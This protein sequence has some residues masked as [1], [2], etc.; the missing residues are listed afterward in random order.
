M[1]AAVPVPRRS[2]WIAEKTVTATFKAAT[3]YTLTTSVD[4]ELG[5][6][7]IPS[8]AP[9][10]GGGKYA[11]G[12][13]VQLTA[14]PAASYAFAN[15]TGSATR[16]ANPTPVTMDGD[17]MVTAHFDQPTCY[18]LVTAA[19][20]GGSAMVSANPA[21]NC[22]P[23]KYVENTEVTLTAT[24]ATDHVFAN[25]SG[26]ATGTENPVQVTMDAAKSVT[27]NFQRETCY[28]LT[29]AAS[30]PGGGSVSAL[31]APTCGG[32]DY[33]SGTV[34]QVTANPAQD[35]VFTSWA[36]DVTGPA[37]PAS[38]TLDGDKSVTAQ[39]EGATCHSLVVDVSPAG[40]GQVLLAPPANCGGGEYA[41]GTTVTLTASP[42][43]G[44]TFDHWSGDVTGT[45]NPET[46]LV[47][48][49]KLLTAHFIFPNE[50]YLPLA[51]RNSP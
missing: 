35:H 45:T 21:P 19:A 24:S 5:G 28:S 51:F 15:W 29:T 1:P 32:G 18:G 36:G 50:I 26:G 9:N 14:S 4:P 48:G 27:A 12:T 43:T 37:N 41:A 31:P 17:K 40:A 44:F 34:V 13:Q 39:F 38:I 33:V 23:D 20:P 30:P 25:W 11:A 46:L 3:C 49:D 10:C 8:P 6:T 47:D 16:T 22:G 2:R 42:D 7:V